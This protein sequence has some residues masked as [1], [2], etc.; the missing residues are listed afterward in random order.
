VVAIEQGA[1]IGASPLPAGQLPIR[2]VLFHESVWPTVAEARAH[3][4]VVGK[5]GSF[6]RPSTVVGGIGVADRCGTLYLPH[7]IQRLSFGFGCLRDEGEQC[8]E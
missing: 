6:G 3:A 1:G 8:A 4:H 2:L 5:E 7:H